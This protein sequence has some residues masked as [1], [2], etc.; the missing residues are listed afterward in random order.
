M[1]TVDLYPKGNLVG[2]F[3]ENVFPAVESVEPLPEDGED[4]NGQGRYLWQSQA[5]QW[6]VHSCNRKGC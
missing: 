6:M 3:H 4:Q 5:D 1:L 2:K